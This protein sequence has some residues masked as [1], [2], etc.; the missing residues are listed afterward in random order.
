MNKAVG[1][2]GGDQ[3]DP[4]PNIWFFPSGF[5]IESKENNVLRNCAHG[6]ENGR[7]I[8]IPKQYNGN[9]CIK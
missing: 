4:P 6:E 3:L 5:S 9:S 8:K 1:G 2:G 7:Q